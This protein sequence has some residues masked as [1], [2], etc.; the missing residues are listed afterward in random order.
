M[1]TEKKL[2]ILIVNDDGIDSPG[3]WAIAKELKDMGDVLVVAPDRQRSAVSHLMTINE[4]IRAVEYYREGEF[5]GYAVNGSPSDCAKLAMCSLMSELPDLLISGIN[6]GQNTSINMM[7]SGTVAGA[8][9]GA[10]RGTPSMAIS[11]ADFSYSADLTVAA[12]YGKIIA[13]ELLDMELPKGA[14]LNVNVP[15]AD[16]AQIKGIR[17]TKYSDSEWIDKYESRTDPFGRKYFWFAGD[18]RIND[19]DEYADDVAL[20]E[21][22]VSVTPVKYQF[23]DEGSLELLRR[24]FK[25]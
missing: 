3:I 24:V 13:K 12:K 9:E 1:N 6:L 17:I 18:Y 7:Y 20:R 19:K 15:K 14:F 25:E 5:F 23:T 22:Y 16:E 10:M 11:I 2:K 4:P 8:V 21:N